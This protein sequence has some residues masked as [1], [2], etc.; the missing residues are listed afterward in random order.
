MKRCAHCRDRIYFWQ[1]DLHGR[2]GPVHIRCLD[3]MFWK[4]IKENWRPALLA[5]A[6][7]LKAIAR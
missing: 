7:I 5:L 4:A 6:E 3:A 1:G 2:Y